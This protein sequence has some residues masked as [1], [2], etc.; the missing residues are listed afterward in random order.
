MAE[1]QILDPRAQPGVPITPY[2]LA[3]DLRPGLRVALVSNGF[4]DATKLLNAVGEA[5]AGRVP[6]VRITLYERRDPSVTADPEVIAKA[7]RENDVAV[8]ALGH[9]GSCTSSATRDAVSLARAGLPVTALIS[10]KF[11]LASA[12]VAR[13]VGMPEVPRVRLPHPV[14]GTG[15]ARIGEI[16]AAAAPEIL[17]AWEGARV[18]AA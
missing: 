17:K 13:S 16:A 5:L 11:W 1:V 12:F 10:E 4:F 14:A 6:N 8:T 7:A 15:D 3:A 18:L 2:T 9:C